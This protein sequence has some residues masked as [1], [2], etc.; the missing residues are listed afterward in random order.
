MRY[1]TIQNHNI[2]RRTNMYAA[3]IFCGE[4]FFSICNFALLY[5]SL[6]IHHRPLIH[7]DHVQTAQGWTSLGHLSGLHCKACSGL[8]KKN[9]Q[10]SGQ[11]V[12]GKFSKLHQM[13][14]LN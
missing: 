13:I 4:N 8:L 2:Q 3:C 5:T 9:P 11:P 10:V 1:I 14:A 6:V 12:Q 7:S